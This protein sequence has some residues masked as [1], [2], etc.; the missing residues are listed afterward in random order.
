MDK[1]YEK[2]RFEKLGIKV[3]VAIRF[4]K[5]CKKMS[6]SQSMTL[7]LMLDF[8]EENGISP[9]ETMGPNMQTLE[10]E[11]KKRINAVIAIIKDIEKNHDKPTTAMLQ[12]LFMEFEPKEKKVQFVEKL[13]TNNQL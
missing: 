10:S 4:R 3:S 12:S 2:E 9:N 13:D 1:G 7:L 5:F 6:K 11:I 8:F